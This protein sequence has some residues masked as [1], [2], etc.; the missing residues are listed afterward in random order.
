[1]KE[2]KIKKNKSNLAVLF[3]S[4]ELDIAAIPEKEKEVF[5]DILEHYIFDVM[6][7]KKRTK[8]ST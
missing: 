2:V 1:M 5:I 6:L 4:T 7:A 3:N 8:K